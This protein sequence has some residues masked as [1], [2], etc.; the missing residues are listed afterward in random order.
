MQLL[1]QI[2]QSDFDS[3]ST[4]IIK[5]SFSQH[6]LAVVDLFWIDEQALHLP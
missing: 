1:T 3:A 6:C 4:R 5:Y 2:D